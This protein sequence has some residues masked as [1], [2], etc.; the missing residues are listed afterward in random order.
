VAP[1]PDGIPGRAW[2]E[3]MDTMAPPLRHLFSICLKEG[4]SPRAWR[5]VRLVL[6]RKVG[7]PLD[8]PSAYRPI[9]LLDEVGKLLERV[10]AACLEAHM[11][12]RVM[13]EPVWVPTRTLDGGR[14]GTSKVHGEGH[15]NPG[16]SG[17][18]GFF[19]RH[20]CLQLHPL[21]EDSGG[22]APL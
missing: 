14:R 19:R 21:N 6:L 9:C 8:S 3:M 16:R 20:E 12:R 11:T 22:T 1:G 7:R 10:V 5:T 15:D 18:S 4:V 2:A 17:D 13:Y